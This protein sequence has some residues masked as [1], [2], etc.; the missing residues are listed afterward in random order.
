MKQVQNVPNNSAAAGWKHRGPRLL[1][2]KVKF[3]PAGVGVVCFVRYLAERVVTAHSHVPLCFF[4]HAT[5][6]A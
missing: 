4:L 6:D 2:H 3:L 5:A 1:G